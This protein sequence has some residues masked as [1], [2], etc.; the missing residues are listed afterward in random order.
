MRHKSLCNHNLAL[1][2]IRM[3]LQM[4]QNFVQEFQQM[5]VLFQVIKQFAKAILA[6]LYYATL[7]E[8]SL[9]VVCYQER[10]QMK[11]LVE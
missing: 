5:V 4:D 11:I 9:S 10:R 7:T 1:T 6:V 3:L 8:R 2:M